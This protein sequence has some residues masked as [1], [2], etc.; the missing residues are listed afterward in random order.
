LK[1]GD[2]VFY[3]FTKQARPGF[4]VGS[5]THVALYVGGGYV[6]TQ[7]NEDGPEHVPF[8]YWSQINCYM[9][10]DVV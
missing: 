10:Y 1:P 6:I 8:N 5:P 9:T 3:G 4:A 7:G 2:C